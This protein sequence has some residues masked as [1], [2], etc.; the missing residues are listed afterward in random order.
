VSAIVSTYAFAE[1][2]LPGLREAAYP[3]R[4]LFRKPVDLFADYFKAHAR[5]LAVYGASGFVFNP[6]LV[7][8]EERGIPVMDSKHDD[9]AKELQGARGVLLYLFFTPDHR[10]TALSGLVGLGMSDAELEKYYEEFNEERAPGI[11]ETMRGAIQF[12][13]ASIQAVPDDGVVL[14]EMA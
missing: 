8:L 2:D 6:L 1:R 10:G 11:G 12:L 3:R 7:L 13:V 9:L 4:R 5:P 14:F